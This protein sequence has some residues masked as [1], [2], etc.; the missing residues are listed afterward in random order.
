MGVRDS[1][2]KFA[3]MLGMAE[4]AVPDIKKLL[5]PFFHAETEKFIEGARAALGDETYLAAWKAGMQTNLN[6]AIAYA[7]KELQ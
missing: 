3:R 1:F 7:L 5:L 6:E 2:E 4:A